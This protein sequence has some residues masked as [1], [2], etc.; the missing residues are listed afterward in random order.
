VTLWWV[1]GRDRET[2]R[3]KYRWGPYEHHRADEEAVTRGRYWSGKGITI[4]V[5][6]VEEGDAA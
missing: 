4:Q 2:G 6:P 1:V 3:I 5:E